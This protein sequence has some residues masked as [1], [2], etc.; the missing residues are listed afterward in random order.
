MHLG[1]VIMLFLSLLIVYCLVIFHLVLGLPTEDR[2]SFQVFILA[3]LKTRKGCGFCLDH[4]FQVSS[5]VA[6]LNLCFSAYAR[7]L[8]IFL[9][10]FFFF[11]FF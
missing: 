1:S 4:Q 7:K 8:C 9:K 6:P 10:V 2:C 5:A 3:L 11:F